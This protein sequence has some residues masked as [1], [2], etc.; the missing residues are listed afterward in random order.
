MS[1]WELRQQVAQKAFDMLSRNFF[2]SQAEDALRARRHGEAPWGAD[3]VSGRLLPIISGFFRVEEN[4]AIRNI[5]RCDEPEHRMQHVT[6]FLPTLIRAIFKWEEEEIES[7]TLKP[8][9]VAKKNVETRERIDSAKLWAIEVLAGLRKLDLLWGMY[10]VQP[11]ACGKFVEL[12]E[13]CLAKLKEIALR[14]KLD[15]YYA[16]VS[17]DRPVVTLEEACYLGSR[18]AWFLKKYEV[19]KT[20]H[21]RL[22]AVLEAELERR[23]AERREQERRTAIEKAEATRAEA[24]QALRELTGTSGLQV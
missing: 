23:G 22:S 9:E 2:K 1:P 16:R 14:N 11:D 15:K 18:A 17:K 8:E 13:P 24:E 21:E 19:A 7:W 3:I 20:E 4:G 5:F 10:G 6:S 12:D